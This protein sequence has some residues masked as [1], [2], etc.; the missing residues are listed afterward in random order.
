MEAR[1]AVLISVI[2]D[3]ARN[4]VTLRGL[5]ARVKVARENIDRAQRMVELVQAKY[6]LGFTNEF[7]L[8]LAKRELATL[9]AGLPTQL[10]AV[11]DAESRLAILLGTFSGSLAPEL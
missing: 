11:A 8:A 2:A 7:D 6:G 1:N 9:Q 3:V 10:A 5:Q 4:Y